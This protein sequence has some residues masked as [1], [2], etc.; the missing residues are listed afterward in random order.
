MNK[1]LFITL[2]LITSSC[3]SMKPEYKI[4]SERL[5]NVVADGEEFLQ[6]QIMAATSK[7]LISKNPLIVIDAIV[8]NE[9]NETDQMKILYKED[10]QEIQVLEGKKAVEIYN[11]DAADGVVLVTRKKKSG[12]F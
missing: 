4:F 5:S 1:I 7:G 12:K 6:F 3:I 8:I 9:E 2:L 10:I 11:L